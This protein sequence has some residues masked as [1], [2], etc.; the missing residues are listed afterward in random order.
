VGQKR[1]QVKKMQTNFERISF[2]IVT[3]RNSGVFLE[4]PDYAIG[5]KNR[6]GSSDAA[7]GGTAYETV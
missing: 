5:Y 6:S 3:D 1:P 2:E 4:C 7:P